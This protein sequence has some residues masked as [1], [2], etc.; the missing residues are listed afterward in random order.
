LNYVPVHV[1][2]TNLV[3]LGAGTLKRC[4][5]FDDTNLQPDFLS[6]LEQD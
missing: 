6:G 4:N 1:L 3:K 2:P 5:F